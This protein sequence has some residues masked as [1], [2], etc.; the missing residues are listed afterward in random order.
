CRVPADGF[1]EWQKTN[2][3]KQPFHI[4]LHDGRP[5]AFAGL[6]EH[7]EGGDGSVVESCTLLTTQPNDLLRPIHNRMPVILPPEDYALWL[8]PEAEDVAALRRL[9]GPYPT[10]QMEAYPVSRYV[11]APRNEGPQCIAPLV[12]DGG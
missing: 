6:W 10:G 1:Y 12:D 5:F 9:L 3:A 7:W 4:R 2:G 8:D 11:N